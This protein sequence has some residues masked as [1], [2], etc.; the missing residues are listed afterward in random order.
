MV[1]N[2]RAD[3]P[4]T[5][6]GK[7]TGPVP[8]QTR[9]TVTATVTSSALEGTMDTSYIPQT[10]KPHM[11]KKKTKVA[12]KK[13]KRPASIP[14]P[15]VQESST[16]GEEDV[17]VTWMKSEIKKNKVIIDTKMIQQQLMLKKID[18]MDLKKRK[19]ALQVHELESKTAEEAFGRN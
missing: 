5:A 19:L 6:N 13:K 18:M 17:C 8:V 1:Q 16:E 3:L 12:S 10:V 11:A 4:L 2:E 7:E 9:R 14:L 15:A